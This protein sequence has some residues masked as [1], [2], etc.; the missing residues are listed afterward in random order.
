MCIRDS[1]DF[2][3]DAERNC[4]SRAIGT[5]AQMLLD[6]D[7]SG[8][9]HLRLM[10]LVLGQD[11]SGWSLRVSRALHVSLIIAICVLYRKIFSFFEGYP[12]VLAC[13]FDESRSV[14]ER[15]QWLQKFFSADECCLDP[16]LS[17]LLRGRFRNIED[18]LPGTKLEEFLRALF[19]LLVATSTQVELQFSKYSALTETRSKKISLKGLASRA[20]N[21]GYSGLVNLWRAAQQVAGH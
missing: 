21:H 13:A 9:T 1:F 16:G 3:G 17:R 18:Y 2:V 5:L 19:E 10:A 12:W 4:V 6:P 15:F 11:S 14:E 7:G 8:R 20:M